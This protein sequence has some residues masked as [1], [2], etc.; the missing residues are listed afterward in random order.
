MF[1]YVFGV[2]E[3]K[4]KQIIFFLTA[5]PLTLEHKEKE[6]KINNEGPIHSAFLHVFAFFEPVPKMVRFFFTNI[7]KHGRFL[8]PFGRPLDFERGPNIDNF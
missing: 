7:S 3:N 4:M 1:L 5:V 8:V 6:I 2:T